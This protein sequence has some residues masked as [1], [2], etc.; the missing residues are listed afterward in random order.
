MPEINDLCRVFL[1]IL[2]FFILRL[3]NVEE[4]WFFGAFLN[5]LFVRCFFFFKSFS[6]FLTLHCHWFDNKKYLHINI[7]PILD[8]ESHLS[9]RLNPGQCPPLPL[10][11]PPECHVCGKKHL[12]IFF[13]LEAA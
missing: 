13:T 12:E 9:L 7:V 2:L 3:A 10:P 8:S 11:P 6:K 4:N 5:I 1:G